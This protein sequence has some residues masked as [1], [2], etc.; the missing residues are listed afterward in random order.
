MKNTAKIQASS[1][2]PQAL[3]FQC[4][5]T[6]E[7][8]SD[9]KTVPRFS[10]VAYTGGLMKVE[11]FSHPV[12]VDLEGLSIDRQNIPIRLDHNPKQGVGHTDR[13][14]IDGSQILADGIISRDTSW[15]RDVS[16][17]GSRGFPWQASIGADILEAEFIPNGSAV[18]VN[19]RS[20]DGPVYVIRKSILK[21][22][23][24]VDNAADTQTTAT[25][26]ARQASDVGLQ[27]SGKTATS[28]KDDSMD[29]KQQNQSSEQK[30]E[31][32]TKDSLGPEAGSL[33]PVL[34]MRQRMVDETRRIQAIQQLCAGRHADIEARAISEGWD[35]T[36]CELEVLRASRPAAPAAHVKTQRSDPKVYEAVALMAAGVPDARMQ[37]SYDEPTLDAAD[38]LR[39]IGIQEYCERISGASHFP[40][41]RREATGWPLG[42]FPQ[43]NENNEYSAWLPGN[44]SEFQYVRHGDSFDR[45]WRC[46]VFDGPRIT[47]EPGYT[48]S[49]WVPARWRMYPPPPRYEERPQFFFYDIGQVVPV[50]W[51]FDSQGR[52]KVLSLDIYVEDRAFSGYVK[53]KTDTLHVAQTLPCWLGWNPVGATVYNPDTTYHRM[54][55]DIVSYANQY[56]R[57]LRNNLQGT[58]PGS[59]VHAWTP[60]KTVNVMPKFIGNG[61]IETSKPVLDV[62]AHVLFR[63]SFVSKNPGWAWQYETDLTFIQDNYWQ[64]TAGIVGAG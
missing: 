63:R 9:E 26:A 62:G 19:G 55:R 18:L 54:N 52:L 39:G 43:W 3:F 22:I 16:R 10:M 20:F 60:I 24:F 11:G 7:A 64:K 53:T 34:Q 57:P 14:V 48:S 40:R 49:D 15:A 59:G 47:D 2:T 36:R 46:V 58:T 21:E 33:E 28:I 8:A 51:A 45:Y 13:V 44:F 50:T 17:S 4:P 61:L 25:V 29:E 38:R 6:I 31:T 5:L 41:F 35:A 1:P 23:S 32:N 12:V 42:E 37:A 30:I 56:W 27:A